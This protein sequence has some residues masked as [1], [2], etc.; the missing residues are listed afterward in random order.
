MPSLSGKIPQ[1]I[2]TAIAMFA[3]TGLS[4]CRQQ[5]SEQPRVES[6]EA[7]RASGNAMSYRPPPEGTVSRKQVTEQSP[8]T[9]GRSE[10]D[11][12][13]AFP[14]KADAELMKTGREQYD[15]YCSH[16]HGPSGYG[17]GM[18]VQRGFP[19][20]PSYH[21]DRLRNVPLGHYFLVITNGHGRMPAFGNRIAPDDRWAIVSYVKA[22]Q[23]SQHAL[24]DDLSES[25]REKIS[26]I[27]TESN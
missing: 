25:D 8:R 27:P 21:I 7:N 12:V 5:M 14:L 9:T 1:L 20:P 23:L 4:G 10:G 2:G 15:I 3:V 24:V 11:P 26:Q 6:L 18:V 13:D 16:C 19:A 17:D 22:L